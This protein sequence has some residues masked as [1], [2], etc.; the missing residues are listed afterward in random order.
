MNNKKVRNTISEQQM[1]V[2]RN[3]EEQEEGRGTV[4]DEA[5]HESEE[6]LIVKITNKRFQDFM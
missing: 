3:D 1:R 4:G 2:K 6:Q 5:G